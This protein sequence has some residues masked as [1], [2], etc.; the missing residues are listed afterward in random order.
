MNVSSSLFPAEIQQQAQELLLKPSKKHPDQRCY[1]IFINA[2]QEERNL[3]AAH[4]GDDGVQCSLPHAGTCPLLQ[5]PNPMKQK[6]HLLSRI[7]TLVQE[8]IA[9]HFN[10]VGDE[11]KKQFAVVHAFLCT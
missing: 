6:G 7:Q 11:E 4:Q 2:L 1:Q 10:F 9:R 5:A 3:V 8:N